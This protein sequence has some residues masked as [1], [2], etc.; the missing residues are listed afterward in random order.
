MLIRSV[1]MQMS[2]MFRK[3]SVIFVYFGLL[4]FVIFNFVS[5]VLTYSKI[6]YISQMYDPIKTL[7]MADSSVSGFFLRNYYPLLLVIPTACAYL[8]DRNTRMQVYI[9]ARVGSVN[10]WYGKVIAVFL[11]TILLFT[12]PFLLELLLNCICFSMQSMGDPSDAEYTQ[13]R[14]NENIYFW[15]GLYFKNRVLYGI[16]CILMIGIASGILAVFNFSVTTLPIMKFKVFAFFPV[17]ILF[18]LISSAEK[19]FSLKYTTYYF[20]ILSMFDIKNKNFPV[21]F[22]FL[23]LLLCISNGLIWIKIKRD[24]VI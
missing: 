18:F 16:A 6:G 5:N 8:T 11:T 13:F 9:Q 2:E 1:K 15:S 24:D 20:Y 22:V 10:Y 7:T 12:I 3:K 23:L 21:Y 19:Y 17:Y 4:G 14:P